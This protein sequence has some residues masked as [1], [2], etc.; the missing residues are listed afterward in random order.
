[1]RSAIIVVTLLGFVCCVGLAKAQPK[2]EGVMGKM[3]S[4]MPGSEEKAP[5]MMEKAKEV[6]TGEGWMKEGEKPAGGM[7]EKVKEIVP[8]MEKK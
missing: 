6:G 3:K 5:G 4:M 2:E 8:G 1:M 7:M